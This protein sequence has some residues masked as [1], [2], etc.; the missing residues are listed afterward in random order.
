LATGLDTW[1]HDDGEQETLVALLTRMKTEERE[2]R[3][4]FV[5]QNQADDAANAEALA[6]LLRMHGPR[7]DDEPESD[8][9][10]S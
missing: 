2:E 3:E 5:R 9:S 8:D 1:L 6:A 10:E 4:E 7:A